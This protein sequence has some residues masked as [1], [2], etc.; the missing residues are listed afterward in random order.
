MKVT[1]KRVLLA[2]IDAF[3][4]DLAGL[5]AFFL[6]FDGHVPDQYLVQFHRFAFL[7]PFLVLLAFSAFKLYNMV[8]RYA[9]IRELLS[10]LYAVTASF[11]LI[12]AVLLI[13]RDLMDIP[14]GVLVIW[15]AL[16]ILVLGGVRFSIRL[17]QEAGNGKVD[18]KRTKV[19]IV[20][21]GD[22][23]AMVVREMQKPINFRLKP[24]GFIDDDRGK[25][26][27]SIYGVRVL[28]T[29]ND[30][31]AI[32]QQ[33]E[34]DEIVIAMPS[35][36]GAT[37]REIVELCN[38]T[39]AQLRILPGIS[40]LIDGRVTVTH[41]RDVQIEDLLGREPVTVNLE[42]M[43]SYLCGQNVLVTGAGG[44]IG[45]E[46]CRQISRFRPKKLILVGHG[47][48]SIYE[49]NQE[50]QSTFPALVTVPV[51][52]D[53]QDL[54]KLDAIFQNFRPGVVFHA[55]AHKHVP[56]ME[57]NPE[58]AV[59]NNILGTK[60]LVEAADRFRA[61]HF[62]MISTD[63]AVNPTSI[64]GA[65]KRV[66]EMLMQSMA[67]KS[68]TKFVAVRFGNVL[69]SR[70]SV[71]PLFKK[72]IARGGPV[73][74][75]DPEMVRYFMTIPEAVQLVIQA[76]AMGEGGEVFVLDM[77]KP[78]K[79]MDL[80][81]DLIR[82]SG[83]E[84]ERDIEIRFT[85]IRPGEKLYEEILTAEEG[86]SATKHS[87]IFVAR[88]NHIQEEALQRG[89]REML[90]FAEQSDV[91]RILLR[92]KELVP[93]FRPGQHWEGIIEAAPTKPLTR[94]N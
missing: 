27:Q 18:G 28:G 21:A 83:L 3:L 57:M 11:T 91:A 5:M 49:I 59:K 55:A 36:S 20:G 65:S 35:V 25:L 30:I 79:I 74:V 40:E 71:I 17:L 7:V 22:A 14:R 31:K 24:V 43:A 64:M 13:D 67:K 93:T 54:R 12:Y 34:I 37:V 9:S 26:G 41:I 80:A 10:I 77:G 82:L 50:L 29:R 33:K 86:T 4:V 46:L 88:P 32:V 23:G 51:I 61:E 58:A 53:I 45:S 78:V 42:E 92:L 39:G 89:V 60:N 44:S 15:W 85:G 72:Q 47:E 94:V 48:N 8:W 6:R 38:V 90:K 69:G 62:V 68:R 66:A 75:T 76:G 63:K 87:R 73:T 2:G 1:Y 52:A 70:G 56:L 81:R 16:N 84:P 19:L